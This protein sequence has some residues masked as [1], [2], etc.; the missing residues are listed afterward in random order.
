MTVAGLGLALLGYSG[1]YVFKKAP[2][3]AQLSDVMKAVEV[4]LNSGKYYKG[5]FESKMTKR[6]A[7]LILGVSQTANTTMVKVYKYR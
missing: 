5:G 6:E 3:I 4:A 7:S 1:R 2:S